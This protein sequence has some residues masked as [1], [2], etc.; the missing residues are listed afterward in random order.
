MNSRRFNR[1]RRICVRW[2]ACLL[3]VGWVLAG[4]A[5][6]SS[7]AEPL[8]TI[9]VIANPYITT[10]SGDQ[11]KDENGRV[12]SSVGT[13]GPRS[14]EK[15]I[16]LVNKLQP[17]ALVVLGSLTW[18][19][20]RADM[21]RCAGYLNRFEAPTFTMAGHRDA[22]AGS[23]DGYRRAVGERDATNQTKSVKGVTLAFASDLHVDL[24]AAAER[25]ES[26]LTAADNS[27]AV[28]MFAARD[29]T[30][31]RSPL[32]EKS[33]PF[34][35]LVEGSRV[36]ARIEPTRYGH[37]VNYENT[38]PI[39]TVGG[40]GWS[41]GGAITV[42][43]VFADRIE[44]AEVADPTQPTFSL[45][46]PNPVKAPRM[47]SAADDPHGCPSYTADLAEQPQFSFALVSDPQ[48]DRETNRDYLIT[49]AKAAIA[50]LNR[51]NPQMVFVAGDLVNNN[52]PEE[53]EMFNRQFAE[54]KPP[55]HVVPGNHDVLFNYDFVEKSYS[56]APQQKPEYAA[57]V[58]GALAKAK[59]EGFT[60]PAALY[61]KYTGSKPRQLI[62]HKD[63]AF[64]TV[65]FLTTRADADQIEFLRAQ[66]QRTRDKQHVFVVAH[67]P[68]LSAFGNNLQ[69]QLGGAEVLGLLSEFRVTGYLFGHRH[70]NG[71]RLHERTAH[72]LTDNML[73][74]HLVHVFA[75]RI[76]VGRK[77]VGRPL[78]EKLTIQ[79]PRR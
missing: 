34:W 46:I 25:L 56:S 31:G 67:Y 54:L 58:S 49:K 26:Q 65:P 66:L 3:M 64:I 73:S 39:W 8:A 19:G 79:S 76:V 63:C 40:N 28:L 48:Y 11:I 42:L 7:A 37:S 5:R 14:M 72:I 60:G 16:E 35:R 50:E 32:T 4:L 77:R 22:L 30:M 62:E 33:E 36:A 57:I 15:S 43:R 23:L 53:W 68:S 6:C 9:A 45:T 55:R 27:A 10:L 24:T 47:A 59:K 71:F 75:D 38:L 12:R 20:S 69:P 21:E 44:M 78:Y 70:R 61:E 51:L 1:L 74:I 2:L 17:D 52:L 13:V 29:R 18:S 41:T